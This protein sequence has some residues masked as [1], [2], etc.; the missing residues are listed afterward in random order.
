MSVSGKSA[1]FPGNRLGCILTKYYSPMNCT[2]T[3]TLFSLSIVLLIFAA[4]PRLDAQQA[5]TAGDALDVHSLSVADMTDEGRWVAAT[6]SNRRGRMGEDHGRFGDATYIPP[7]LSEVLIIDSRQGRITRPF[8]EPVQIRGLRWSPDGNTLAFFMLRDGDDSYTLHLYDRQTNSIDHLELSSDKRISS[9]SML[10]W[11]PDGD[12]LLIELR[13]TGWA[14][15]ARALYERLEKGP[16]IVQ[17]SD[18][19]FLAWDRVW[20]HAALSIPA[21]VEVRSGQTRELLPE[22]EFSDF[23]LAEN[24]EFFTF[25]EIFPVKTDYEREGDSE[26]ELRMMEWEGGEPVVLRERSGEEVNPRWNPAGDRYAYSDEGNIYLRDVSRDS[27]ANITENFREEISE[28][29]DTTKYRFSFEEWHPQGGQLLVESEKGYHLLEADGSEIE[30]VYDFPENRDKAPRRSIQH[31]SPDGR[32]LYMSYSARDRWERG[33]TRYD[34]ESRQMENLRVDGNLYDDWEFSEDGGTILYEMSDGDHPTEL[35]AAGPRL[36][37]PR[38]LTDIDPWLENRTLTTTE[39][40]EY[41]D[42]DGDTL[43]G[44]LYYPVDYEEGKRYPLVAQVYED[45]FSNGFNPSMNIITNAG[46]FGFRPS[47]DLEEGYPGEAW[48]KG[49][50][51]A[52]NRLIE[53]G[54]V[55]GSKLG[56]Q[57]TSYGGYAVNLLITQTD[58][59]AAAINISGKV[60]MISFL[61][62]SPKIT[63]RNYDAA[64]VGQDRIGETLWEARDKYIAHSA[65][66]Y[67]DRIETPL[68]MLT[69]E[70]DWNVPATNQRE[71]YYALRRLGKK[72][73]WVHY[74]NAGHGAGRAGTVED[75]HHHWDTVIDWYNAYFYPEQQD[76]EEEGG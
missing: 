24:G 37:D 42:V 57:G 10:E 38:R 39:L 55:D 22:M 34:L 69:G 49:V 45:F 15:S 4:V 12:H 65:V 14:D 20:N 35:Y 13:E 51:T 60:N 72:V 63:T 17:D 50:T 73:K 62:D 44:I 52:I 2:P 5:F 3:R 46:F 47:V 7:R 53:R 58:R 61:G 40:I 1:F 67:A 41:M 59:F 29:G 76:G 9:E 6:I 74:M 28:E 23:N 31:W 26:Y 25:V 48:L 27:A 68:L 33:I 36:D 19:D 70:G 71:M 75:Y 11:H 16:V 64:E 30:Q 21:A 56:V 66:F 54:L 8:E 43:Y 18:N 32:Y